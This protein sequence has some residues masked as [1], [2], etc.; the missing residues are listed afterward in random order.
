MK[1]KLHGEYTSGSGWIIDIKLIEYVL[2][3]NQ[4]NSL[5]ID[6]ILTNVFLI[7]SVN[8]MMRTLAPYL[9]SCH[10]N[11]IQSMS[12]IV[13]KMQTHFIDFVVVLSSVFRF[14]QNIFQYLNHLWF[15]VRLLFRPNHLQ[16]M[17]DEIENLKCS[18]KLEHDLKY[19]SFA[20]EIRWSIYLEE[21]L[22]DFCPR[23]F[24][25]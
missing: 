21:I 16:I 8:Q 12:C 24:L 11:S 23:F 6:C 18:N 14:S 22:C 9:P 1:R 5:E 3:K 4:M 20:Q 15:Y 10:P 25:F 13:L 2:S 17:D 19:C 7:F